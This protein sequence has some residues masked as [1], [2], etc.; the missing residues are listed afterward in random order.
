ML[1]HENDLFNL[2]VIQERIVLCGPLLFESNLYSCTSCPS[3]RWIVLSLHWHRVEVPF[4]RRPESRPP[5]K[6]TISSPALEFYSNLLW[7]WGR[8]PAVEK[9]NSEGADWSPPWSWQ[10]IK[11]WKTKF[12]SLQLK[13]MWL[14]KECNLQSGCF[15]FKMQALLQVAV[16]TEK[17][18]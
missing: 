9:Q 8:R 18:N 15:K 2:R 12:K 11:G 13:L 4:I 17:C 14:V 6:V 1:L 10:G 7:F 3:T 5:Y 16:K